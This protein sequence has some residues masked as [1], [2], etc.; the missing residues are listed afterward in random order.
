MSKIHRIIQLIINGEIAVGAFLYFLVKNKFPM[1]KRIIKILNF[2]NR[3]YNTI[4]LVGQEDA[5]KIEINTYDRMGQV[6]HPDV[7]KVDS[8]DNQKF[9]LAINPYPFSDD[10]HENPCIYISK[11]GI[12]WTSS[13]SDEVPAPLALPTDTKEYYTHLSDPDIIY[14]DN[15]FF[16]YYRESFLGQNVEFDKIYRI[17]SFNLRTWTEP[18]NV[19]TTDPNSEV[20]SPAAVEVSGDYFV[21]AVLVKNGV[22]SLIRFSDSGTGLVNKTRVEILNIPVGRELWHL[23]IIY[24]TN[25]LKG[26]FLFKNID[27][28]QRGFDYTLYYGE[29]NDEGM[30]WIIVGDPIIRETGKK[31]IKH[32]YRASMVPIDGNSF[33]LYFTAQTIFRRWNLYLIKNFVPKQA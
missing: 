9:V 32:I 20:L 21:F 29:S 4:A 3:K 11:N 30:S 19:L 5:I 26:L 25:I 6:V 12:D 8:G 14:S 10:Q 16:L 13:I 24:H 2:G 33:N 7:V 28:E 1:G 23:D 27:H 22:K 17:E 31:C 18:E 15:K